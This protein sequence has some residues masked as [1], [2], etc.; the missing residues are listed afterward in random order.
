MAISWGG[1]QEEVWNDDAAEIYPGKDKAFR[2][3]IQDGIHYPSV[4]DVKQQNNSIDHQSCNSIPDPKIR[5]HKAL[6]MF[7][8]N[9]L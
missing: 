4:F 9:M 3:T 7:I 1:G 6:W 8:V 2:W 5:S